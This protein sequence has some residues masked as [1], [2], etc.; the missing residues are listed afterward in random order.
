MY[1][2]MLM[3]VTILAANLISGFISL[4]VLSYYRSNFSPKIAAAIGMAILVLI[5]YPLFRYLNSWS[6]SLSKQ[7][8][9]MGKKFLGRRIGAFFVF[10]VLIIILY[11][12]YM[13]LW[14][15]N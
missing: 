5:L 8:V 7:L 4:A 3:T 2:F 11:F 10:A 9:K 13:K 14:F 1:K 12:G 15:S 6:N